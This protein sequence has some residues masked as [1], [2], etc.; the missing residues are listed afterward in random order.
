MENRISREQLS[1]RIKLPLIIELMGDAELGMYGTFRKG[2]DQV[3]VKYKGVDYY[4]I[5]KLLVNVM[6]P[7]PKED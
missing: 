1:E 3:S 2:V 4:S 5:Y 6:K 7:E